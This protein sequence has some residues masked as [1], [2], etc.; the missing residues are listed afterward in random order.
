MIVED[1]INPFWVEPLL[2]IS[3]SIGYNKSESFNMS[4]K[5]KYEDLF[6]RWKDGLYILK[7]TK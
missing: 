2:E 3:K 5:Q 4:G 7:L 1:I 6:E